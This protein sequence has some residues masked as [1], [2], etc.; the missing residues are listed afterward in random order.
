VAVQHP[1]DLPHPAIQVDGQPINFAKREISGA[2]L[3][4]GWWVYTFPIGRYDSRA[5]NADDDSDDDGGSRNDND[6]QV[7]L[8]W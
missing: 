3:D 2:G 8:G 1:P 5:L 7:T 6:W 4:E